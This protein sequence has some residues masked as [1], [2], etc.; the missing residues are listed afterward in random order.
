MVRSYSNDKT[1]MVHEPFSSDMPHRLT[2]ASFPLDS[3]Y[4]VEVV[5]YP[6]P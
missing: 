2:V 6:I 3:F 1:G 4:C 5:A